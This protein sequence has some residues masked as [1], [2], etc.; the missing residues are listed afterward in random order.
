[1]TPAL[2]TSV[3]ERLFPYRWWFPVLSLV[4]F[5]AYVLALAFGPSVRFAAVSGSVLGPLVAV[6]WAL[7][8][9]CVWFHPARGNLQP[10]S[11]LVGRLPSPVQAAIRWYA[12]FVLALFVF[13]GAVMWPVF[14]SA[15]LL[16]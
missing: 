6:P 11:R 8:C 15:W 2:C 3:A 13:M 10:N 14:S 16:L 4:A 1:M 12:A 7:L 9:V 5:G